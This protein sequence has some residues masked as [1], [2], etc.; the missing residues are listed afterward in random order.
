VEL[1]GQARKEAEATL[2]LEEEEQAEI[3]RELEADAMFQEKAF[4][5][6]QLLAP[7]PTLTTPTLTITCNYAAT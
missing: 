3:I 1:N 2:L 5:I 7:N 6:G 4:R